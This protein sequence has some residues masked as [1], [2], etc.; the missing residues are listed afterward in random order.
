MNTTT[1]KT[2]RINFD[3]TPELDNVISE[4]TSKTGSSSKAEFIRRAIAL[5]KVA[6]EA[7]EKG[8]KIMIADSNRE[9]LS[10]IL[11]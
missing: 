2:K 9:P 3:V 6:T 5:M 11:V 8:E 4:L 1:L 7:K 10:E